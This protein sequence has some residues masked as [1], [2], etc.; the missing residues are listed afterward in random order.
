MLV[1]WFRCR[2]LD[3]AGFDRAQ[4]AWA[5]LSGARGFVG[6]VGGRHRGQEEQVSILA[7]WVDAAAYRGFMAEVHDRVTSASGQADTYARAQARV[8]AVVEGARAVGDLLVAGGE[9]CL[10]LAPPVAD[11]QARGPRC[12][13]AFDDRRLELRSVAGGRAA[14][15]ADAVWIEVEPSWVVAPAP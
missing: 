6:Q 3:P 10:V 1:K 12:V 9:R 5:A 8:G 15:Q 4:R 13:I 7:A 11:E 14:A 2:V